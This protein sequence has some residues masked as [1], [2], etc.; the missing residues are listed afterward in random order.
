MPLNTYVILGLVMILPFL[1]LY[2]KDFLDVVMS[3]EALSANDYL[4]GKMSGYTNQVA[5]KSNLFGIIYNIIQYGVFFVPSIFMI[6]LIG[7]GSN[8]KIPTSNKMLYRVTICIILLSL[9]F[10]FIGLDTQVFFYRTLYM[11]FIPLTILTIS[12]YQEGIL[13]K[14]YFFMILFLGILSNLHRILLL[15][16]KLINGTYILD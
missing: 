1:G 14:K 7:S 12:L 6:F 16:Y 2:L 4:Y 15:I 10:L 5:Q 13:K 11:T 8:T 9:T 3:S